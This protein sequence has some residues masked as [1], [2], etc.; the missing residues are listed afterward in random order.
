[1]EQSAGTGVPPI[2]AATAPAAVG[3]EVVDDDPGALGREPGGQRAADAAAGA[4]DDDARVAQRSAGI[5]RRPVRVTPP[6]RTIVWPVSQA[7][8][9]ESRKA[10]APATSSGTPSRFS[11]YAADTSSSRPS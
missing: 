8:S 10:T 7:A 11:G 5:R 6:S 3:V 2:S 9:S 1:M 4:G